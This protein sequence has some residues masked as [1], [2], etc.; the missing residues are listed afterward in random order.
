[1]NRL[2]DVKKERKFKQDFDGG[3]KENNVLIEGIELVQLKT[4]NINDNYDQLSLTT[5]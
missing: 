2:K 4:N 1:M 5:P 3:R